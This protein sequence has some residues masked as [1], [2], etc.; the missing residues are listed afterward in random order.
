MHVDLDFQFV[1]AILRVH[2]AHAAPLSSS[3]L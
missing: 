3:G 1:Q 2:N